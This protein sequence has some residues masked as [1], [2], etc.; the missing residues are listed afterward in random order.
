MKKSRP[1]NACTIFAIFLWGCVAAMGNTL[2]ERVLTDMSTVD[3]L[4]KSVSEYKTKTGFSEDDY[5]DPPPYS[6]RRYL[7]LSTIITS[8]FSDFISGGACFAGP[9][10]WNTQASCTWVTE[11]SIDLSKHPTWTSTPGDYL[12]VIY[13]GTY[14]KQRDTATLEFNSLDNP[15]VYKYIVKNIT[16]NAT[17][18]AELSWSGKKTTRTQ[19]DS[20]TFDETFYSSSSDEHT[21]TFSVNDPWLYISPEVT[22]YVFFN[23]FTTA[24]FCAKTRAL[25][26]TKSYSGD[27][28]VDNGF[29]LALRN[30][31]YEE[32]LQLKK[33]IYKIRVQTDSLD[34]GVRYKVQWTEMFLP[35]WYPYE[36]DVQVLQHRTF[37][38][39]ATGG[40]VESPEY[41]LVPPKQNGYV[42][43]VVDEPDFVIDPILFEESWLPPD[44]KS[45]TQVFAGI[46]NPKDPGQKASYLSR[47]R[48]KI[49]PVKDGK[50]L[51]TSISGQGTTVDLAKALLRAGDETGS[52][53]VMAYDSEKPG[54]Y[55]VEKFYIACGPCSD[56]ICGKVENECVSLE[57]GLGKAADGS[58]AGSLSVLEKEPNPYIYSPVSLHYPIDETGLSDVIRDEHGTVRQV[59][60]ASLIADVVVPENL[61]V[62]T[63]NAS[64]TTTNYAGYE[65]RLYVPSA[66]AGTSN[67]L[68]QI[69]AGVDPYRVWRIEDPELLAGDGDQVRVREILNGISGS[70]TNSSLFVWDSSLNG[71]ELQKGDGA[72]IIKRGS[73]VAG[74]TDTR[75]LLITDAFGNDATE[76][77]RVYRDYSWGTVLIQEIQDPN[78]SALTTDYTYYNDETDPA[79][80]GKLE[81]VKYPDGSWIK[82][83]YD[84]EG[85]ESSVWSPWLNVTLEQAAAS[86]CKRVDTGYEPI[87]SADVAQTN[88]YVLL[89]PR[90]VTEY[91]EDT[92]VKKTAY[93]Y[94]TNATERIEKTVVYDDP[95]SGSYADTNNQISTAV[96]YLEDDA[97]ADLADKIKRTVS[98]EGL[99]ANYGYLRGNFSWIDRTA[100]SFAFTANTNGAWLCETVTNG[101]V[102]SPAGV[103]NK[104]TMEVSYR[105]EYG[106]VE[107]S[108]TH[109]YTGS[110]YERISWTASEYDYNLS[111]PDAVGHVI[112]RYFSDGTMEE[113]D[114]SSC[115]G[116]E[117]IINRQGQQ[118]L[119]NYDALERRDD[120]TR[121]GEG[122]QPDIGI[123]YGFDAAG[124]QVSMTEAGGG[125][126]RTTASTYD[127]AGRL[128]SS[129][130]EAGLATSYI[131]EN[132]G[133]ISSV[134]L[135]GGAT[136]VTE[137]YID[138]RTKRV[139][140]SAVIEQTYE[141]GF[142]GTNLWTKVYSGPL[143]PGSPRWEK[144]VSDAD[145]KPLRT[146]RP[147]FG[148]VLLTTKYTNNTKGQLVKIEEFE[149]TALKRVTINE[150]DD[151]G[152]VVRS[153]LDE[154]Q[155]GVLELASM[156]RITDTDF[157]YWNDW[158]N[159]W[160]RSTSVSYPKGNNAFALTNSVTKTRLTGLGSA[161]TNGILTGE[162]V[163]KDVFGSETVSES[164]VSRTNKTITQVVDIPTSTDD[165]IS[166]TVNGLLQSVQSAS[167]GGTVQ[168]GYDGLG[169]Q[170]TVV[171]PRI[172]TAT[173]HYNSK[174][175]VDWTEDTHGVKTGYAYDSETGQR[176]SS[177]IT[178]GSEIITTYTEFD[179]LGNLVHQWGSAAYPVAY[180]YDDF[181]QK[182][183][184]HTYRGGSNWIAS[185]WAGDSEQ[186]DTTEW[187][188]DQTT[189]L[190]TNK[191][192]ADGK[193][194]SY[195]YWPDGKLKTRTWARSDGGQPLSTTYTYADTGE[196]LSTDYSDD[197]DDISCTYYRTGQQKTVT[198]A[199]GVHS[200][201]YTDEGLLDVEK[202]DGVEVID[203]KHD[204]FGHNAG[205]DVDDASSF[206]SYGYDSYGRFSV[207]T[208]TV[209]SASS[210]I[211]Y[212]Y[213]PDTGL[214]SGYT[215]H[216]EGSAA[217]LFVTKGYE[218]DRNIISGITNQ[219]VGGTNAGV[220]SSFTYT[221]DDLG[222]RTRRDDVRGGLHAQDSALY[223]T[224]WN[225]G[226]NSRSE[227]T[228]AVRRFSDS[229]PVVGQSKSYQYDSIGNRKNVDATSPSRSE[230]Y[231][232]NELNQYTSRMIP[233]FVDVSGIA[234]T[235]ATVTVRDAAHAELPVPVT[236]QDD[237]FYTAYS[238]SNST[239]AF[240]NSLEI[241]AVINPPGT[242][243]PDIVETAV[244]PA[245]VPQTPEQ[246][247][248][249]D[250]GNLTTDGKNIYVYNA[251][252]RLVLVS[253]FQYQVSYSYD[254]QGR[255]FKRT[256][257]GVQHDYQWDGWN[258]IRETS[259]SATNV[260][261]WGLDLS[262]SLQGAGGVGGL[263][264]ASLGGTN[265][266]YGFDANGNVTDL[267]R[268]DGSVAAQYDYDSFGNLLIDSATISGNPFK[269]S[270][271][272]WE[273]ETGLLHYELRPY[274]PKIGRWLSRDPIEEDGGLNLYV[275]TKNAVVN[276]FDLLGAA[277]FV[278]SPTPIPKISYSLIH[279][280]DG[281]LRK[282]TQSEYL[283]YSVGVG[284]FNQSSV[285]KTLLKQFMLKEGEGLL[286]SAQQLRLAKPEI[287]TV[288][289]DQIIKSKRRDSDLFILKATW[290]PA[291]ANEN[292]TFG[293]AWARIGGEVCLS[294][295]D[296]SWSF[297]GEVFF[298]DL[299]DFDSAPPSWSDA[300]LPAP[301]WPFPY[302]YKRSGGT[303]G[304]GDKVKWA[305]KHIPGVPFYVRSVVVRVRGE[306]STG[307]LNL[308]SD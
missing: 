198:D 226:Y 29:D 139:S 220:I 180:D 148:G 212:S 83:F 35:E 261:T 207:I 76:T 119:Y 94:Y 79:R 9:V 217:S 174:G 291:A 213:V 44:E 189:G 109:V 172:G 228:N 175:Q 280:D 68:F 294:N 263:M 204:S 195:T 23:E 242:N 292:G 247:Q 45:T 257:N 273:P 11:E 161:G 268:S 231:T 43:V 65:V 290:I 191:L 25:L 258:I 133:R 8:S 7:G 200:F 254:Y 58:S 297:D 284:L 28:A 89:K 60:T 40:T 117:G 82:Y 20:Y 26:N 77:H 287:R 131:Y 245:F 138:G 171:D 282:A 74:D 169:R 264:S 296:E 208:S 152:N 99:T 209:D 98:A 185:V 266:F 59:K 199:Q 283:F 275:F 47:I 24:A 16:E 211:D 143:G 295:D 165:Q 224:Y 73:V 13:S 219:V 101:I 250:D 205:Y 149:G 301:S 192:Y 274:L 272:F 210:V 57:I 137:N 150:Y 100:G 78:G 62:I 239:A 176:F 229:T 5:V 144:T 241:N 52:I 104:T 108:E 162:S 202:L 155:D 56:G 244:R 107:L 96:Y 110:S 206:V 298:H 4:Y 64:Y 22:N 66:V 39:V 2:P 70:K 197:T 128:Q 34:Q 164:W 33:S 230:V 179:D 84:D 46:K 48:W 111:Y 227:M 222:R 238:V 27:W 113:N 86:N 10:Y 31:W 147:G 286:L 214:I 14:H 178:N 232:A 129:T 160:Q 130:N 158:T 235:N 32:S 1:I 71:W 121:L 41:E 15:G 19:T 159:W 271:K 136:Q 80:M 146:E 12:Q 307:F 267:V 173:T 293:R 253:N 125:L 105:N 269:F 303:G 6:G 18:N 225:F 193:G 75:T 256:V 305:E 21:D 221:N 90:V 251:E 276:S 135:P 140:G 55:A 181:G 17:R 304:A 243:D 151:L 203:R 170:T 234:A 87:D 255:M 262:G 186:A 187:L 106:G 260:F 91:I 306:S 300:H 127:L 81:S 249:D 112:N 42:H 154:D 196:L 122:T 163:S 69:A 132:G 102:S 157:S 177:S 72:Q 126:T 36:G 37:S 278:E 279:R 246:L 120:V 281:L 38:F 166:I 85:R 236:R 49:L 194:P 93:A 188:Y 167:G 289:L 299:Y 103:A 124:R 201:E 190:V 63:T 61:V 240:T 142:D 156:D 53:Y 233:G 51:S 118:E 308:N 288:L 30:L 114:W 115:C 183:H 141:Y 123:I 237:Y 145:G 182:T 67:G 168:Y 153:G 216:T 277:E 3:V 252:N 116:L 184:L 88:S 97:N 302:P 270:T 265:V 92:P 215:A 54:V 134:T 218:S 95:V 223:S 248:Y 259:H 50:L 285:A